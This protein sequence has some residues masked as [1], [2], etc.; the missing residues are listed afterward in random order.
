MGLGR[1]VFVADC[2]QRTATVVVSVAGVAGLI[3][4]I[5]SPRGRNSLRSEEGSLSQSVLNACDVGE[6][7]G[8]RA[9][10][11]PNSRGRNLGPLEADASAVS[12]SVPAVSQAVPL[13]PEYIHKKNS[14]KVLNMFQ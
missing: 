8:H 6:R 2:C 14:E 9:A 4:V 7:E 13:E 10:G 12:E 5:V 1:G 3:S 11:E